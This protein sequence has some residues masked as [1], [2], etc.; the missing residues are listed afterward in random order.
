MSQ[1]KLRIALGP[2]ATMPKRASDGSAG[3]D[4]S[5]NE[6]S[7]IYPGER[8]R[9]KTG[10]FLEIP[11]GYYGRVAPR[12][13]L[14]LEIGIDVLAGVIDSDYRGELCVILQNHGDKLVIVNGGCRI[15]QLI[16]EACYYPE[17]EEVLT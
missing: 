6:N 14:A 11:K 16:I 9:I 15:A 12:N 10:V 8:Q 1:L 7:T 5:A 17:I 4:L 2:G 13:V 3:Y